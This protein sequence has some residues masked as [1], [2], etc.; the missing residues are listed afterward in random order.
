MSDAERLL[1]SWFCPEHWQLQT[2]TEQYW[3][4]YHQSSDTV[5]NIDRAFFTGAAQ[6]VVNAIHRLLVIG[7]G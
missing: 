1:F 4:H 2:L 3:P 6:V 7:N 5:A